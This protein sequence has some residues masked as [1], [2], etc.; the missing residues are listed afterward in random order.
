MAEAALSNVVKGI[1]MLVVVVAVIYFGVTTMKPLVEAFF[2]IGVVSPAEIK[3]ANDM[4]AFFVKQYKECKNSPDADCL[5]PLSVVLPQ[6]IILSVENNPGLKETEFSLLEG[7]VDER[8]LNPFGRNKLQGG[9]AAILSDDLPRERRIVGNDRPSYA[10]EWTVEGNVLKAKPLYSQELWLANGDDCDPCLFGANLELGPL[11]FDPGY[12]YKEGVENVIFISDTKMRGSIITVELPEHQE[13]AK[14]RRCAPGDPN[15]DMLFNQI[16]S[17]FERCLPYNSLAGDYV[18]GE[19]RVPVRENTVSGFTYVVGLRYYLGK[20]ERVGAWRVSQYYQLK[21]RS[22]LQPDIKDLRPDPNPSEAHKRAAEEVLA[23]V[24]GK[25]GSEGLRL[26]PKLEVSGKVLAVTE[27]VNPLDAEELARV[28]QDR[29]KNPVSRPTKCASLKLFKNQRSIVPEGFFIEILGDGRF[30]LFQGE[31]IVRAKRFPL[32]VCK[33]N[34]LGE[35]QQPME[36][37]KLDQNAVSLDVYRYPQN[38]AYE[39][40]VVNVDRKTSEAEAVRELA[41]VFKEK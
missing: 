19:I 37:I 34:A 7:E 1:L 39:V 23:K 25:K 13:L 33:T 28:E 41:G 16:I 31:K 10:F 27:S 26:L 9:S 11:R 20:N 24:K 30:A 3:E 2:G 35:D 29:E 40:C 21:S 36:Y 18:S 14:L 4:F 38:S 32:R 5:C 6:G 15:A 12:L 22:V 17:E 8:G